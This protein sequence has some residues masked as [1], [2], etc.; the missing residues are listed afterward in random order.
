MHWY[1]MKIRKTLLSFWKTFFHLQVIGFILIGAGVIFLT[2]FTSNNA[3]EIAISGV[4][5]VFIG[6]GVNNYS[7]LETQE[8]NKHKLK[9][10][11]LQ[12]SQTLDFVKNRISKLH[13][14]TGVRSEEL[15]RSLEELE[16]LL[17]FVIHQINKDFIN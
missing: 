14:N 12:A 16:E 9:T 7:T 6:I 8:R 5:S 3:L 4:A 11:L 1:R 13:R 17:D 10:G 15:K 2:F